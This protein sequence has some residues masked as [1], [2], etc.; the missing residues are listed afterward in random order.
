MNL[1]QRDEPSCGGIFFYV[2]QKAGYNNKNIAT[3]EF[4][5]AEVILLSASFFLMVICVMSGARMI[6][7]EAKER[8]AVIMAE[9][10][11]LLEE[12]IKN[13]NEKGIDQYV[14]LSSLTGTTGTATK[15]GLSGLPLATVG[16]TLFFS[17]IAVFH[18]DGFMDL[19]KLT[20]GGIYRL[21]CTAERER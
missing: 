1:G 14:R 11:S 3:V 5:I 2:S 10:R 4:S 16:L 6:I 18:A 12:L 20:L 13:G 8:K 17:I 9:D 15:L 19:A 7:A 21:L